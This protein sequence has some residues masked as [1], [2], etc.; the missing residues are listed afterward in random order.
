MSKPAFTFV[1]SLGTVYLSPFI[2]LH[3]SKLEAFLNNRTICFP[4]KK[5]V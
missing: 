4:V 1:E 5:F 3:S 2:R